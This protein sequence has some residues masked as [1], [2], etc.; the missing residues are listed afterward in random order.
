MFLNSSIPHF[1]CFVRKE[2]LYNLEKHHGEFIKVCVFGI[3]SVARRALGF[4]IM[5]ENG[6]QFARI[7]IHAL[8]HK[9][10]AP[11]IPLD[12]LQIWDCFGEEVSVTTFDFLNELKCKVYLKNKT[13]EAGTYMFTVDWCKNPFSDEPSEYKCAHIIQLDNGCYCAQP[14]NRIFWFEASFVVNPLEERPD[15]KVNTHN[16]VCETNPKWLT[17]DSDMFFYQDQ[18]LKTNKSQADGN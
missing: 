5:T 13:W 4:H 9:T 14:N 6:A 12:Y 17:E 1:Y 11:D 18:D 8:V 3:A 2:F 10:N 15:Y 7:P 16:W